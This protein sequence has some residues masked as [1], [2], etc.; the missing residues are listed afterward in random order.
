MDHEE[1]QG[2]V[3]AVSPERYLGAPSGHVWIKL[4][5]RRTE[6][7]A[8][9]NL[10]IQKGQLIR[11]AS[12]SDP[13]WGQVLERAEIVEE[14][15][16]IGT[17]PC[18]STEVETDPPLAAVQLT[19]PEPAAPVKGEITLHEVANVFPP[20][21][22]EEY[23]ALVQD[24]KANGLI[25]SIKTWQGKI[26]DGRSRLQACQELGIKPRFQEWD[27]KG[28]LVAYVLSLNLKRRHL[29]ADQKAAIAVDILPLL[30]KEAKERQGARTDIVEK[31]PPSRQFGK[32]RAQAS[33]IVGVNPH[34]VSDFKRIKAIEPE[35]AE[36]IRRGA[37]K[38]VEVKR[39]LRREKIEKV[40]PLPHGRS[41]LL[42]ADP[43]W[44]YDFSKSDSRA[45]EAHYPSLSMEELKA[46]PVNDLSAPDSVLFLWVPA[47][48]LREG[49]ELMAAW[50]FSYKTGAVWVKP[51]I[52]PGYYFRIAH[53]HLLVGTKGRPSLPQPEKRRSSVIEAARGQLHS[54]KPEAAYELIE[55]MYPGS[56]RLELFA[57]KPRE[58]WQVWG[59]LPLGGQQE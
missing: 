5:G 47:P 10:L 43:P 34:Y 46:L 56:D 57:R 35:L 29:T 19:E 44:R 31:I 54:E 7:L 38:I 26:I 23:Q 32:A 50:G 39:E 16:P 59:N 11:A 52:G 28:S 27:G 45:V 4:Q 25:E 1:L 21:T 48:K 40:A 55:E 12:R 41:T 18:T 3:E 15:E 9:I 33:K 30:E 37:K 2:R 22:P 17:S 14:P 42:C 53:E 49:L 51:S 8:S 6:Y 24:I 58:G 20:M 36:Q 13:R